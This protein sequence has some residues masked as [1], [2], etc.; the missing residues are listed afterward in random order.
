MSLLGLLCLY[1]CISYIIIIIIIIS[2]SQI[3]MLVFA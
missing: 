1:T 2:V 3:L